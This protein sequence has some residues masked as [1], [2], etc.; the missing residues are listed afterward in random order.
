MCLPS[1]ASRSSKKAE[2]DISKNSP[3][4]EGSSA[5]E[6]ESTSAKQAAPDGE[7]ASNIPQHSS[8]SLDSLDPGAQQKLVEDSSARST[9]PQ[10]MTLEATSGDAP[11]PDPSSPGRRARN[12]HDSLCNICM[13]S[14]AD[15]ILLECGH[16]VTCTQCGKRL[17]NCPIC[18]QYIS[19]VVRVFRS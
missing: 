4:H 3:I 6:V 15:C 12:Q 11:Q 17:A 18:R 19:R 13:D 14:L 16:M 9:S 8:S 2:S 7:K 1:T 10:R 5:V